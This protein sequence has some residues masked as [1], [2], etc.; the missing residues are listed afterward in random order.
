MRYFKKYLFC[1]LV[2]ITVQFVFKKYVFSQGT[3]EEQT[4]E[5]ETSEEKKELTEPTPVLEIRRLEAEVPLYSIELRG[6]DLADF[7]RVIAHDYSL[8]IIVDKNV[9]GKVVASFTN[10]SLEEA[11]ERIAEIYNLTL[12]KKENI[13]VVKPKEIVYRVF[14]LKYISVKDLFPG[15]KEEE[16]GEREKQREERKSERDEIKEIREKVEK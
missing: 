12:E 8:N 5:A 14:K 3:S 9:K 11:L 2:I 10:I 1:I 4:K 15:L 7:F 13:I 16:R 6:V